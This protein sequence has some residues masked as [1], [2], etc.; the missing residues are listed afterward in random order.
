MSIK[1][2]MLRYFCVVAEKGNLLTA[3][4]SLG[5]TPSAISMMLKQLEGN[6]GGKLFEKDRKNKLTSLGKYV[7]QQA[8][9]E[10]SHFDATINAVENY[11]KNPSGIL[12]IASVP[13]ATF[14][15]LASV[16]EEYSQEFPKIKIEIWDM[17]S[18][19]IVR[20]LSNG[21]IKL[22]I[23][24]WPG[25]VKN[26]TSQPLFQDDFGLVSHVDHEIVSTKRSLT[27]SDLKAEKLI[28]NDLSNLI[29]HEELKRLSKD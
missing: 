20:A 1:I 22:G 28:T 19:S 18:A 15:F 25:D 26:L 16:I 24:S 11:A 4:E 12:R 27:F 13:S 23:A 14:G 17:D 21:F 10:I 3:A 6:L 8:Q 9:N 2:E 7:L 5:R 29:E